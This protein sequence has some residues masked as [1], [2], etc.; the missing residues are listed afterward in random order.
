LLI[1][2]HGQRSGLM[3]NYDRLLRGRPWRLGDRTGQ[4]ALK[5]IELQIMLAYGRLALPL[6]TLRQGH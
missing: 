4:P 5:V 3:E 1:G 6:R 2:G